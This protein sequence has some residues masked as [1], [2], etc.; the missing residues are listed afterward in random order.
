M[1]H[2]GLPWLY[3]FLA[4]GGSKLVTLG[5]PMVHHGLPWLP[6]P[7]RVP[8]WSHLACTW[9]TMACHGFSSPLELQ[10]SHA[11]P[12]HGSPWLTMALPPSWLQEAPNWSHLVF[13]WF[14]MACHGSPLPLGLQTARIW[15]S[16]G[17]PWLGPVPLQVALRWELYGTVEFEGKKKTKGSSGVL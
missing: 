15:L 10:T 1:V 2:Q 5:F 8:S 17:S 13:P 12:S 3:P 7:F 14:S 16:H 9:F 11:W 4:S 6:I